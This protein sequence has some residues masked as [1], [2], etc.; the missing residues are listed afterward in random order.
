MNYNVYLD[1]SGN[2]GNIELRQDL[3]WNYGTQSHFALGSFYIEEFL[4][5]DIEQQIIE[6]LHKYNPKL[7]TEDELKSKA[8]YTFR[9]ELLKE[10]TKLLID[11]NVGFYFDIA[12]KKY[13]VIMNMVEYCVYPYFVNDWYVFA[14]NEKVDA[15][16]F[17]YKTL[18]KEKIKIY[19]DLC[20]EV[21]CE[22][23]KVDKL[24]TFLETLE[25]HYTINK[26][27]INP[28]SA[29]IDVVKNYKKYELKV[30]NLFPVKDFNNKGTK[31]SFLPNVDAYNS[32]IASICNLRIGKCNTLNIYHD[33]QKQ[34]SEVLDVWTNYMKTHDVNINEL[35]FCSSKD[36]VLVQI[37]DFYTGSIIRLYRKIIEYTSLNRADNDLIKILKP[38]LYNCNIVAPNNEQRE[39]F[40]KCGIKTMRT[41]IPF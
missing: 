12:N 34:F 36:N 35:K 22:E 11:N 1:E 37:A 9:N 2:T 21:Y 8:K 32:I 14:R 39:F 5:K 33:E 30:E 15:A 24:I 28:V 41:P 10:I 17:L 23:K 26:Q 27:K 4:A 13:K 16:N 18:P 29:V 6:I 31:E 19:I 20:Q 38:L 25:E 3:Q 7:G 40:S